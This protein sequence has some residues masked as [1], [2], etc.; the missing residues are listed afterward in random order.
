MSEIWTRVLHKADNFRFPSLIPS[1]WLRGT[2]ERCINCW[3]LKLVKVRRK[4]Q[5]NTGCLCRRHEACG[6]HECATG[7]SDF[8]YK[9]YR[10]P[11]SKLRRPRGGVEVQ[12]YSYFNLEARCGWVISATPRPLYPSWENGYP[13]YRNLGGSQ[14]R[15]GRVRKAL[16]PPGFYPRTVQPVA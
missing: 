13:F 1:E 5:Q 3:S 7:R 4:Q 6:S 8:R 10:S 15:S 14:S 12:L 9:R 2:Y 11:Y 16:P